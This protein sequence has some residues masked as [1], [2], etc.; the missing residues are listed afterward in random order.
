MS[1]SSTSEAT[2]SLLW[3][4]MLP[5]MGRYIMLAHNTNSGMQHSVQRHNKVKVI[6]RQEIAEL[7]TLV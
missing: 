3:K 7:G 4:G 6:K 5:A 1:F 2:K